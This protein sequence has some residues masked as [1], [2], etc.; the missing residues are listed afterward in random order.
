MG[1]KVMYVDDSSVMRLLVGD[2]IRSDAELEWVGE[3]VNGKDGLEKA[4]TLKPDVILSDIEMPEMDGLEFI[5]R[6]RLVSRAKV[7]VLSSVA[8]VGSP[9][10]ME[11][12]QLGAVDV[13][14]K[15]SG[16][17]S[18]DI[19]FKRGSEILSAVRK[20]GGLAVRV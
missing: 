20:A 9:Q 19:K 6:L 18:I 14:A 13:I 3:A 4:K 2:L 5:K 10:A 7:I 1:L 17:I 12:R 11:A 8:Q 16:A 15:P